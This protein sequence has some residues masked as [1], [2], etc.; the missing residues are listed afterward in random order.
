MHFGEGLWYLGIR[1]LSDPGRPYK[2]VLTRTRVP[3]HL[4]AYVA[5]LVVAMFLVFVGIVTYRRREQISQF[6]RSVV[7][8]AR[9]SMHHATLRGLREGVRLLEP[10]PAEPAPAATA[11]P[12]CA[13]A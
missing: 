3:E 4:L 6:I 13:D 8:S 11:G 9:A 1:A 7:S 10:E 12:V 5:L 2:L